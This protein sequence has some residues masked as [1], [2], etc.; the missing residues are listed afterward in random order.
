LVATCTFSTNTAING[1]GIYNDG[2]GSSNTTLRVTASTLSGNSAS[3]G[4]GGFFNDGSS[5]GNATVEI[6]DTISIRGA[7]GSNFTNT[8]GTVISHG[9]NLSSDGGGGFLTATGDQ[10]RTNAMLGPLQNNGG[11][12]LTHALLA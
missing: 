3:S 7:S 11:P 1:G 5:A 2:A 9:Y 8:L 12:T 4:G 10:T 6:G